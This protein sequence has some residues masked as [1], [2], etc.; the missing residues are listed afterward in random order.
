MFESVNHVWV[1]MKYERLSNICLSCGCTRKIVVSTT[2]TK[3]SSIHKDFRTGN[4]CV[5]QWV[6]NESKHQVL[7]SHHHHHQHPRLALGGQD[8]HKLVTIGFRAGHTMK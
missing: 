6:I 8:K 4:G 5:R 1:Q 2:V 3:T 7:M